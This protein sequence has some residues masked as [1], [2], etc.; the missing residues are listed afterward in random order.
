MIRILRLG[1][2]VDRGVAEALL[3]KLRLDPRE[4][5]LGGS[6]EDA[7]V[8]KTLEDVARR[9]DEALV[10]SARRFDD[11]EFSASQIR[12]TPDEMNQAAGRISNELRSALRR[13]I[14]QVR[15]YQQKVMPKAGPSFVREGVEL[16]MRFTPLDSA[17][18]YF[19]G[20]KASY[21]ST[22]IMLA[23]P[24]QVAGVEK[25]VVCSPPSR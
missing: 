6:T 15:Q 12:V 3:A 8:R 1:N 13:A 22:L 18:L 21:P 23:V 11:P 16:G 20:G 14:D 17:G 9:G 10:E 25:I 19:P 24:A 4:L 7:A 2:D 5:I